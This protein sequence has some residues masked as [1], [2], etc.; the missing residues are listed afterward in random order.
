MIRRVK[1][2]CGK[3]QCEFCETEPPRLTGSVNIDCETPGLFHALPTRAEAMYSPYVRANSRS[4]KLEIA[5]M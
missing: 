1:K 4:G 2:D 5:G 3:L